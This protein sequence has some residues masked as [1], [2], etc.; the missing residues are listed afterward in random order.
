MS[1]NDN[2]KLTG[3]VEAE[4]LAKNWSTLSR[5]EQGH[6]VKELVASG[7]SMR[8]L[9]K[10]IG[11]S[12]ATIRKRVDL[13]NLSPAEREAVESGKASVKGTLKKVRRKRAASAPRV[14]TDPGERKKFVEAKAQL[15]LCWIG[16]E[17]PM[18]EKAIAKLPAPERGSARE[19]ILRYR[20][21][22]LDK[23]REQ[24]FFEREAFGKP[25][26]NR[27]IR[28]SRADPHK[29][30]KRCKPKGEMGTTGPD[31]LNYWMKWF[32][33][34]AARMI[35][36]WRLRYDVLNRAIQLLEEEIRKPSH[37]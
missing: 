12:E 8:G 11:A 5:F 19:G 3:D 37:G 14:P 27:R 30:I 1:E 9:A 31:H 24:P 22:V 10:R 28:L 35:A 32:D 33:N 6:G 36:D 20:I 15:T 25:L 16:E 7:R 26:Q 23:A 4:N 34:W 13:A 21:E 17:I 18:D 29:V 2:N